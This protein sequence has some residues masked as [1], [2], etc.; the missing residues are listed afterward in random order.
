MARDDVQEYVF[1][2]LDRLLD[3]NDISFL[4]WDMNR[5]FSEPGWPRAARDGAEE[6]LGEVHAQ[7]LRDHRPAAREASRRSR[8]SRCSGGGGRVDL[9]ILER[10]EQ[11]WTSD[12][13]EAFDRLRI[14]EGFTPGLHAEGDD[15]VGDRRAEHERP[16]DAAAAS[17]SSSR[18]RARSA[19]AEI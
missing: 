17:A 10:V 3:E 19:S 2:A 5:H 12:N 15:G 16:R 1:A 14:Q 7:R 9:G 4:K 13:T 6:D 18:C 8:S 11:V